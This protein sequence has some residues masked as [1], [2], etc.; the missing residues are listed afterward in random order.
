VDA[1]KTDY[2]ELGWADRYYNMSQDAEWRRI[3]A[4]LFLPTASILKVIPVNTH[5]TNY[6]TGNGLVQVD[7]STQGFRRM[8][9][10]ISATYARDPAGRTELLDADAGLMIYAARGKYY[11]PQTSNA[12]TAKA[13]RR[14]GCPIVP[15]RCATAGPTFAQVR[16]CGTV[17]REHKTIAQQ[18]A[19]VDD[20]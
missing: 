2:V 18:L 1:I 11:F 7:L 4:A 5:P 20:R 10:F 12:W 16:R 19:E 9:E 13:L 3:G 17:I 8:A 6:C 15:L 14:A